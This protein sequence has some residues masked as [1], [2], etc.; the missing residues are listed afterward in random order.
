MHDT[1]Q[2]SFIKV[3]VS[4]VNDPSFQLADTLK[5]PVDLPIKSYQKT[6]GEVFLHIILLSLD[7]NEEHSL[8][9][10][11]YVYSLEVGGVP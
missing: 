3:Y 1:A 6:F 10:V 9:F 2:V 4:R 8:Y 5:N 11:P 7:K